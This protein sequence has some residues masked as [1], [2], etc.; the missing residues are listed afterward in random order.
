MPEQFTCPAATRFEAALRRFDEANAQ[1]PN[2]ER[3]GAGE[4]PRELLYARWLSD[5][6]LRLCPSASEELRLAARCQHLCR[7]MI[8]RESYPLTRAGYLK[9]REGLKRFHAEKAAAI[10]EEIGYGS[11]TIE[12]VKTLSLKASFPQDPE[13]RVLEDALC[14]VF[15][16]HQLGPLAA[17]TS[18]DKILNAVRKSWN[19]M[20]PAA[21]ELALKLPLPAREKEL[22]ERALGQ[23]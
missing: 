6:V 12:G 10:L 23:T 9:W 7:W 19:K 11:E 17:H 16:E 5:W 18:E 13:S 8:P 22:I 2:R 15:L 20:T 21:R 14:L 1:D 4:V 3:D